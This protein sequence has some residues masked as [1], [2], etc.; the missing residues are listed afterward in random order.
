MRCTRA[1]HDLIATGL[2]GGIDVSLGLLAMY[3][4]KE[5]TGSTVAAALAF[6]IGFIVLLAAHSELFTENYLHPI[7]AWVVRRVTAASVLR[8]WGATLVLNL[9]GGWLFA[10]LIVL[11]LPSV[12]ATAIELGTG[13]AERSTTELVALGILAGM[14]ITLMT[15]LEQTAKASDFSRVAAAVGIAFVFIVAHLNHVIVVSIELFVALHTGNAPFGYADWA[16][17]AGI[18]LVSNVIGGIGLVTGLR[19]LQVGRRGI[20]K[21]RRHRSGYIV[22]PS[23]APPS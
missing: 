22:R 20:E 18:A 1:N 15:W 21:E 10:W 11:G 13:F 3:V 9:I 6:S 7:N 14:A 19:L 12:H 4:V 23:A 17:V 2:M 5:L 16:R 8:L